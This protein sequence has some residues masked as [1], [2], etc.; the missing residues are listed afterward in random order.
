VSRPTPLDYKSDDP[1]PVLFGV[2][3]ALVLGTSAC[4]LAA[5]LLFTWSWCAIAHFRRLEPRAPLNSLP[6]GAYYEF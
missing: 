3:R 4:L 5:A 6:D 2:P 1:R